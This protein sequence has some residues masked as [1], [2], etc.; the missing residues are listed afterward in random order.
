MALRDLID[1]LEG[2]EEPQGIDVRRLRPAEASVGEIREAVN[3]HPDHPLAPV[4]RAAINGL[5]GSLRVTVDHADLLGLATNRQVNSRTA[6]RDGSV[7]SWR[8]IGELR[9]PAPEEI[10]Q[11][12]DTPGVSEPEDASEYTREWPVSTKDDGE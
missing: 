11:M 9:T 12:V 1:R 6:I 4:F 3:A 2:G 10:T 8:E 7:V 5:P